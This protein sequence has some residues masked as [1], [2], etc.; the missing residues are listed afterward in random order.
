MTKYFEIPF[1]IS[2]DKTTIPDDPQP[3]GNVSFTDGYT[4]DYEKD[5]ATDPDAKDVP[6]QGENYFKFVVTE[7]L[8]E[9]QEHGGKIYDPVVN[10]PVGGIIIGSD[11]TFYRCLVK[12][13]PDISFLPIID[14][15]GDSTGTWVNYEL[16]Y[17]NRLSLKASSLDP[18]S[19]LTVELLGYH[20]IGDG[21][22]GPKSTGH[23]GQAPG[24]YVDNGGSI[25]VP[26]GGDGSAAWL[27][28]DTS[29][30]TPKEFG[31]K[32]DGA[33]DDTAAFT[34]MGTA[35]S[36]IKRLIISTG[37]YITDT[38]A[39]D[40]SGINDI[41]IIGR[42]GTL[43]ALPGGT[44][45]G[46]ALRFT[47][48]LRTQVDSLK[49]DRQNSQLANKARQGLSFIRCDELTVENSR[50]DDCFHGIAIQNSKQW[51]VDKNRFYG[52]AFTAGL[53]TTLQTCPAGL[54]SDNTATLSPYGTFTNNYG[55]LVGNVIYGENFDYCNISDNTC[56]N[57]YD[58]A[59]YMRGNGNTCVGNSI[60]KAG[61]DGIKNINTEG[62][63]TVITGNF[64]QNPGTTRVDG[65]LAINAEGD[66]I[67]SNNNVILL[68]S[69][70]AGDVV[71][72]SNVGVSIS[73]NNTTAMNNIIKGPGIADGNSKG[74]RIHALFGPS[75][76]SN[77]IADSNSISGVVN[78]VELEPHAT[79]TFKDISA[80]RNVV[81]DSQF[82]FSSEN[83]SGTQVDTVKIHGNITDIT[84]KQIILNNLTNVTIDSNYLRTT[85]GSVFNLIG[86]TDVVNCEIWDNQ[87]FGASNDFVALTI[88]TSTNVGVM[89]NWHDNKPLKQAPGSNKR[90]DSLTD[91]TVN[92]PTWLNAD[93]AGYPMWDQTA[94]K[95]IFWSGA[96]WVNSDGT[97]A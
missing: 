35:L 23:G 52:T 88:T 45:G 37:V 83:S 15:V 69:R 62:E 42:G 77:V 32:G 74:V 33:T 38:L 66:N 89:N 87:I 40:I 81:T 44:D 68:G 43:K 86:V 47:D 25:T 84:D 3:A 14:P 82:L 75:A 2:G 21:G 70:V 63:D 1:A 58:T 49:V 73:G 50:F 20:D 51:K 48:C 57:T 71:S 72:N 59:L 64:I 27:W 85:G 36:T 6:R 34:A 16:V 9:I 96:A 80:S 97:A 7:A 8:K 56:F 93:N 11:G 65:G 54:F 91:T 29:E 31:A 76:I 5:Q 28:N 4:L 78:T 60:N 10:Y 26:D 13:G 18:A 22:G 39:M 53:E 61:K 46:P 30:M 94:G 17:P 90:I 12:N 95:M 24:F 55:E 79:N 19:G 67:A 41:E 92:R